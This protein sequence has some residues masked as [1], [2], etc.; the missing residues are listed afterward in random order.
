MIQFNSQLE[1]DHLTKEK[2]RVRNNK[3]DTGDLQVDIYYLFFLVYLIFY[4]DKRS[5]IKTL[6]H[7]LYFKV[8]IN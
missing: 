1:S 7:S 8:N 3:N 4:N 2:I 5:L 6:S